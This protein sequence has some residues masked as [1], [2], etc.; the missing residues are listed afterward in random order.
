MKVEKLKKEFEPVVIT[1]ESES[2]FVALLKIL[3]KYYAPH[4]WHMELIG[5]ETAHIKNL[6]ENLEKLLKLNN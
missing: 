1:L 3:R 4:S 6:L 5:L 2:E